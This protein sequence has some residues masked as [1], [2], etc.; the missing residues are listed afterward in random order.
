MKEIN[1]TVVGVTDL[2]EH[3]PAAQQNVL[4]D[5][6]PFSFGDCGFSLVHPIDVEGWILESF[7]E[8]LEE[9]HFKNLFE[10]LN[11]LSTRKV[12]IDLEN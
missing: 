2:F 1:L 9:L 11:N 4:W 10:T 12:Y 3:I 6:C 5:A 8:E 7:D